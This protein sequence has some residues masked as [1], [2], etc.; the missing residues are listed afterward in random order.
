[1]LSDVSDRYEPGGLP[2]VDVS[3]GRIDLEDPGSLRFD[4]GPGV[5][6]G[7]EFPMRWLAQ[8]GAGLFG[9]AL[10]VPAWA[11]NG[12]ADSDVAGR[13]STYPAPALAPAP[14]AS[15][16]SGHQHKGLFG[17]RHCVECQRARAKAKDGIDVPPPPSSAPAMMAPGVV[18]SSPGHSHGQGEV[19]HVQGGTCVACEQAAAAMGGTVVPGSV[20]VSDPT[21]PGYASVGGPGA[22]MGAGPSPIGVAR[23][24]GGPAAG[25]AMASPGTQD[26]SVM[27]TSAAIPPAPTPMGDT[28]P[29]RPHVIG[30]LFGFSDMARERR[31]R[32]GQKSDKERQQHAAISYEE[33]SQAVSELPAS[34]VYGKEASG[35]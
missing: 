9:L 17:W 20:V 16:A 10:V 28:G 1:M 14:R 6:M 3:D 12:P 24:H 25:R 11:Q 34:M 35:H 26:P 2:W 31:E 4:E 22:E 8:L 19:A 27:P 29:F 15:V 32:R 13:A 18:V 5:K 7:K 30:H 33:K 21:V 23:A